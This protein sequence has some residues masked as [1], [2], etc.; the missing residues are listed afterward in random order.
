MAPTAF[1]LRP[2]A[3]RTSGTASGLWGTPTGQDA[4][5]SQWSSGKDGK[6]ILKLNGQVSRWP[7]PTAED[8]ESKGMSQKRLDLR[9]PDN[10][11]TAVRWT[12]PQA[13]D[14]ALGNPE[15]VGRYGTKHGGRNLN[16]EVAMFP[17][18]AA[19]DWR[20]GKGRSENGHTP[21][22]PEQVGGQ[23]NP[24]WVEWLMG[25]PARWTVVSGSSD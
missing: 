8:G 2:L 9:G 5:G 6:R 19:R 4:K 23:L 22:L 13:H 15:R 21:Q 17:S 20:S 16:D 25:L 18:P 1:P 12:T 10:L 11:A 14:A 24:T 3:H 7:T